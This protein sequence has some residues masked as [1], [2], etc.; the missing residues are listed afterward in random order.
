M[1][2]DKKFTDPSITKTTTHVN[3]NDENLET[4]RIV[5]VNAYPAVADCLK[6]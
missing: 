6:P 5:K 3:F 1:Y 4:V 2:V